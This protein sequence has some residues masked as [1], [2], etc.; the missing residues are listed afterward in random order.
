VPE[1]QHL[2]VGDIL[3]THPSGGFEVRILE[4]DRALVLY[5][6]TALVQRQAAE[7][8]VSAHEETPVNLQATS[9]LLAASQ[10]MDFAASW[11]FLL[12]PLDG[13]TRVIERFRV[14]F[15]A[16]DR[17]W[18][19][20]TLPVVG[21]GVFLMVRRQLLGL[22][23]RVE[24]T[25]PD[26]VVPAGEVAI[27]APADRPTEAEATSESSKGNGKHSV[28]PTDGSVPITLGT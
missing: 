5:S 26:P 3:P 10:P 12:E 18:T 7:A 25:E 13:R 6:D 16:D 19:R 22:R 9:S 14:R 17:P 21:F 23:D 4:P 8:K 15:G 11:A 28:D 27:P 2:A 24:A 1:L 20:A